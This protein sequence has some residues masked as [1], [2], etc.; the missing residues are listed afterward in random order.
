MLPDVVRLLRGLAVD[1]QVPRHAKVV[2][3]AAAGYALIPPHRR[4]SRVPGTGL[5]VGGLVAV[6]MAVRHLIAAA[7]YELV[8]DRWTGTDAGFGLLIVLAGVNR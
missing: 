3:L 8:H 7:G 6:L 4:A 5:A 2:A 1:P